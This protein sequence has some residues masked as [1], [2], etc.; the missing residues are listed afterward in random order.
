MVYSC[1]FLNVSGQYLVAVT[2][3]PWKCLNNRISDWVFK[4]LGIQK[5]NIFLS[6]QINGGCE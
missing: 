1:G 5:L 3:R 4:L 6:V 2:L